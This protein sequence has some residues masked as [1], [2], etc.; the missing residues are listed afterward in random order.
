[1]LFRKL[2]KLS[3]LDLQITNLHGDMAAAALGED[4]SQ[5]AFR[6]LDEQEFQGKTANL[7]NELFHRICFR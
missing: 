1:M 2:R 3:L 7:T 4:L 5:R 6:L